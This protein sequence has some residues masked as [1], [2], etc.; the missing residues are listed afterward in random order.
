M[1]VRS[2]RK[3]SEVLRI[4][5][6]EVKHVE[7]CQGCFRPASYY[8]LADK[9]SIMD[10]SRVRAWCDICMDDQG[11]HIDAFPELSKDEANAIRLL[12]E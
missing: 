4:A 7:C 8:F 1:F 11:Y 9:K 2:T 12:E 6:V 10:H 3:L 5:T